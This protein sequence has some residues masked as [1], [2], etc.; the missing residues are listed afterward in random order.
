MVRTRRMGDFTSKSLRG[1]GTLGERLRKVREERGEELS[2]IA[3]SLQIQSKY[4]DAL[5]CGRYLDL[6]GD[7]YVTSFLKRY[8]EHLKVNTKTVLH[9][10]QRERQVYQPQQDKQAR[11]ALEKD[12]RMPRVVLTPRMLRRSVVALILLLI[13]LYLG[14]EAKRIV[15]PPVLLITSPAGDIKTTDRAITIVGKTEPEASVSINGEAII[16]KSTGEFSEEIQLTEGLNTI[17]I[18]AKKTHSAEQRVQRNI[19]VEKLPAG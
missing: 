10:Y 5:E 12:K 18:T 2:S 7:V 15:S 19:L 3:E 1:H 4:L 14:I 17:I 8:A 9:L 11:E 16:P 13:L 6:P